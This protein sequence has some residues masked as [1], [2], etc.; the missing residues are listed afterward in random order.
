MKNISIELSSS[1]SVSYLWSELIERFGLEKANKLISQ[2]NDLQKMNGIKD[3]TMPIV[4]TGTGG[5]ALISTELLNLKNNS[6]NK[7]GNRVLIFNP[8]NKLFQILYETQ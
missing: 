8:K 6:I 4:F 2:A 7:K 5:L 1:K 3:T